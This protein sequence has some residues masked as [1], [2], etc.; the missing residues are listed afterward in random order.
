LLNAGPGG[1]TLNG[2]PGDDAMIA[3]SG[4]DLSFGAGGNDIIDGGTARQ[5][6]VD[7]DHDFIDGGHGKDVCFRR[8]AT[9][10]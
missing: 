2:G 5:R 8:D 3:G 9:R 7:A 10:G 4:S 6:V 1:D